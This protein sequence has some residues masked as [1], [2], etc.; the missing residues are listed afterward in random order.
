MRFHEIE[1]V[2]KLTLE[3][4]ST[5]PA[6]DSN[7]D[8]GRL[9]YITSEERIYYG[10]S[11]GWE[12][13]GGGGITRSIY[14]SEMSLDDENVGSD[15]GNLF[16]VVETI[17]FNSSQDGSAWGVLRSLSGW[18]TDADVKVALGYSLNGEDA[19][20]DVDLEFEYYM[21]GYSDTLS[22]A[23]SA[24]FSETITSDTVDPSANIGEWVEEEM[25]V[26]KLDAADLTDDVLLIPFKITRLGSTDTYSGTFQLTNIKFYQ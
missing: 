19:G 15:G 4:L 22:D 11:T 1:M 21:M 16:G 5:L 23:T 13:V 20:T 26:I 3:K 25:S 8:V 9:V 7:T 24:S 17:D 14:P 6:F 18:N 2:G 12:L 10:V